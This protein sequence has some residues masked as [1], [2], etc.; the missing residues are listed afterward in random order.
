MMARYVSFYDCKGNK[1]HVE[2]SNLQLNN[3]QFQFSI[4]AH[5]G[6]QIDTKKFSLRSNE[7]LRINLKDYIKEDDQGLIV[8]EPTIQENEFPSM[9]LIQNTSLR[10]GIKYIPFTRIV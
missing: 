5:D 8:I 10:E 3:S 4:Y 1:C 9:L 6:S 2:V 7:T